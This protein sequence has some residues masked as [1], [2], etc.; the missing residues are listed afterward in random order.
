M[1]LRKGES[2]LHMRDGFW[3]VEWDSS[4]RELFQRAKEEASAVG[5]DF[6]GTEHL[7]LAAVACSPLEVAGELNLDAA[8]AAVMAMKKPAE[9]GIFTLTPWS[10]TPRFKLAIK[11]AMERAFIA[12]RLVCCIDIWYGLLADPDSECLNL[13]RHLGVDAGTLRAKL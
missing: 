4:A 10:Q 6:V 12:S 13:F 3:G 1:A 11:R 9:T 8:R 2:P 5:D 7:L